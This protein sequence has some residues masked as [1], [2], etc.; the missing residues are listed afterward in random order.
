MRKAGRRLTEMA[1]ASPTT[2]ILNPVSGS[3]RSARRRLRRLRDWISRHPTLGDAPIVVTE[4]PG[5]GAT[6]TRAAVE[7]G[8]RRIVAVGGDGTMNEIA[9]V[10]AGTGVVFGLVPTGSG[11]GLAGHLRL[12]TDIDEAL[13]VAT[14][15]NVVAIDTGTV[16]GHAFFNVMG[17]GFDAEIGRLF[18]QTANRGFFN[19]VATTLRQFFSYPLQRY[20]VRADNAELSMRAFLLAVANSTQY[21]NN[22]RIAPRA[23]VDDGLL[24]IVAVTSRHPIDAMGLAARMFAGSIDRSP[25]VVT[26]RARSITVRRSAPG[27]IHTDGEVISTEADLQ[28]EIRPRSLRIA[29]PAVTRPADRG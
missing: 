12:P 4:A 22:A 3:R 2:F 29:V 20:D 27:L 8:A 1:P 5:H 7:Q 28:I 14:G 26:C 23:Q 10:L 16:N 13:D 17:S 18:N 11:N 25:H 19:Y 6:L 15:D 24:D 21:G 9:G